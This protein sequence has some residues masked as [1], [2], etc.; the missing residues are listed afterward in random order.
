[1]SRV[2]FKGTS[3]QVAYAKGL[4]EEQVELAKEWKKG[5]SSKREGEFFEVDFVLN[6]LSMFQCVHQNMYNLALVIAFVLELV[7]A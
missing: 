7:L 3:E 5:K 2:H 1:M 6:N 4:V